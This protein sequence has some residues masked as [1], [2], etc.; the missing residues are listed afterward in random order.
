MCNLS[1]RGGPGKLRSYWKQTI[2]VMRE[3]VGDNPVYKVSPETG[4][5]PLHTLHRNL[6]LQAND[7]PVDIVQD[8]TV[9]PQ[10]GDKRSKERSKSPDQF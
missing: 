8:P 5:C 3:Q 1:E 10:K 7:L 4:G 2:Y 6:L 9:K